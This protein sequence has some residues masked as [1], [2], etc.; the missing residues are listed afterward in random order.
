MKITTTFQVYD[1]K[2]LAKGEKKVVERI[3]IVTDAY[4]FTIGSNPDGALN[5]ILVVETTEGKYKIFI[6]FFWA[7]ELLQ[8]F[9]QKGS[10]NWGNKVFER[11]NPE[12]DLFAGKRRKEY[13]YNKNETPNITEYEKKIIIENSKKAAVPDKEQDTEYATIVPAKKKAETATEILAEIKE[14]DAKRRSLLYALKETIK[15][16]LI[17]ALEE[18]GIRCGSIVKTTFSTLKSSPAVTK[19]HGSAKSDEIEGKELVGEIT[20]SSGDAITTTRPITVRFRYV[21]SEKGK[22]S[23]RLYGDMTIPVS[24]AG[25]LSEY[26][27]NNIKPLFEVCD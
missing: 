19:I 15:Q 9:R 20:L 13:F 8:E 23:Q 24:A 25:S 6:S 21:S 26:I 5:D 22:R 3:A 1:E 17:K 12:D 2:A 7:A 18:N 4:Y 14:L 27:K 10:S 16:E 11:Y